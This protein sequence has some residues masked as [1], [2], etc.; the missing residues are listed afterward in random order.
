MVWSPTRSRSSYSPGA[1]EARE[2]CRGTSI[3]SPSASTLRVMS[4]KTG[5]FAADFDALAYSTS[6]WPAFEDESTLFMFSR[7]SWYFFVRPKGSFVEV[8]VRRREV[9]SVMLD[10]LDRSCGA[11][12]EL[13]KPSKAWLSASARDASR[14]AKPLSNSPSVM[15][16]RVCLSI[17]RGRV[18]A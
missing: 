4:R 12:T 18:V 11:P 15:C 3:R 14:M 6:S 9:N 17:P 1:Y 7:K 5:G 8:C 10:P 2:T 13:L 16:S